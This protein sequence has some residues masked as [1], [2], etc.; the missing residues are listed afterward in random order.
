L[1]LPNGKRFTVVVD[2]LQDGNGYLGAVRLNGRP[3]T[4]TFIRHEEIMSGG[5]LRFLMQAQPDKH[6]G[7]SPA[8]RPYSLSVASR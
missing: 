4:R 1:H 6:W 7:A 3:L 5:E 8:S 2:N